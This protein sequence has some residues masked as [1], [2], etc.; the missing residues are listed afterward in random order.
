MSNNQKIGASIT[1]RNKKPNIHAA[2]KNGAL[3]DAEMEWGRMTPSPTH[4]R[5]KKEAQK[6]H[7]EIR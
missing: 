4:S 5:P 7:V 2:M 3:L 6:H 1:H